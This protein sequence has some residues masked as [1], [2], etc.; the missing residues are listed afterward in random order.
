M[1]AYGMALGKDSRNQFRKCSCL[2]TH[3]EKGGL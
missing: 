3:H 2:C 1:I